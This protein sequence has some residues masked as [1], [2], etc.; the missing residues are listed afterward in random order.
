MAAAQKTQYLQYFY[1]F[2]AYIQRDIGQNYNGENAKQCCEYLIQQGITR[3]AVQY[4]CPI[5]SGKFQ[6]EQ[7]KL[8]ELAK[9]YKT[10]KTFFAAIQKISKTLVTL[11]KE[12]SPYF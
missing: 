12:F 11:L 4:N 5:K 10:E 1:E 7:K 2:L 3:M 8:V 6:K 9:D